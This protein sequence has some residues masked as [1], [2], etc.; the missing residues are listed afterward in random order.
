M[1]LTSPNRSRFEPSCCVNPAAR[2]AQQSE[3]ELD[4][5]ATE[6]ETIWNRAQVAATVHKST[7][8]QMDR[9]QIW[10]NLCAIPR[11]R[12]KT[13][14]DNRCPYK[15]IVRNV[16]RRS[17]KNARENIVYTLDDQDGSKP[18]RNQYLT[19]GA[20]PCATLPLLLHNKTQA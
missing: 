6:P 18:P 13:D 9:A 12:A 8:T 10:L 14:K 15:A 19:L 20:T 2:R 5:H 17:K 16:S 4:D 7:L 3:I 11:G 1:L